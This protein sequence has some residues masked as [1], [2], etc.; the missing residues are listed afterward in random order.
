MKNNLVA[1]QLAI[2][3][4]FAL[5]CKTGC[6]KIN[7]RDNC[8]DEWNKGHKIYFKKNAN[9]DKNNILNQFMIFKD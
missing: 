4:F 7:A 2:L 8:R 3:V 6:L 9:E 1:G 5:E